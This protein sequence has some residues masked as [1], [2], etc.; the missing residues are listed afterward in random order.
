MGF[1]FEIDQISQATIIQ[2]Q[3]SLMEKYE[4]KDLF[5]E[6]EEC[7]S[8]NEVDFILDFE[9][10]N[11]LS[12]SGLAV[13]LG[14]LTRSRSAGGD[15]VLVNVNEKLKKLLIITRLDNVFTTAE[16]LESAALILSENKSKEKT[17]NGN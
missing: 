17:A 13:L 16:S 1:N 8:E 15:V 2:F 5:T 3:G 14:I 12:S 7:I 9:N 11:Y 10:L 6:V 4:A